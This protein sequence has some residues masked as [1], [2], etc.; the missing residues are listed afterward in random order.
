MKII[1]RTL[2]KIRSFFHTTSWVQ[3]VVTQVLLSVGIQAV[4]NSIPLPEATKPLVEKAIRAALTVVLANVV[5]FICYATDVT[6]GLVSNMLF[7]STVAVLGG[8]SIIT[9][10]AGNLAIFLWK[11]RSL[12]AV[13]YTSAKSGA[14][15]TNNTNNVIEGDYHEVYA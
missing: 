3:R 1:N 7:Y 14:T 4:V 13:K 15:S 9:L 11:L 6:Q 5:Y 8:Y 10:E 12:F 2:N